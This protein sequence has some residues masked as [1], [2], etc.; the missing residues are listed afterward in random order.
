MDEELAGKSSEDKN[1]TVRVDETG[2][3]KRMI[4]LDVSDVALQAEKK[5]ISK[6]LQ[7]DLEVPG[8]RKGKVPASFVEKNY[9]GAVHGDAVQNLL[10]KAYEEAIVG[11]DLR[12][13]GEPRFEDLKA[14]DGEGISV[15]A[16]IEVKPEVEIKDY[17][18]VSL[19]AEKKAIGDEEVDGT[20]ETLVQNMASFQTVDRPA[21]GDDYIV[22]DFAPLLD[23]GE[24]DEAARQQ[25]YGVTLDGDGLL[26]EFKQGLQGMSAGDEKEILVKY[27][28]DFAEKN[29]AGSGKSFRVKVS[30]VKEKLL[31]VL[32]DAF[33]KSISSEVES[34]Q[35]LRGRIQQDLQRE[36][37][38]KHEQD[39]QEKVI[40]KIIE[41]NSFEVP[42]TMVENYLTSIVEEDRRRR[43]NV[44][45]EEQR[46][47]Q[48]REMFR[49][50]AARMV[51]RYLIMEAVI[52]QENLSVTSEE[53][54]KKIDSLAEGTGRPVEEVEKMFRDSRHRRNLENELLDQK[55]LNF[56]RVKA[57]IKDV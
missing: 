27:P 40:D 30:E 56:L 47:T 32:D 23:S 16:H 28:D 5:R 39:I 38:A 49:E 2:Q 48:V 29:L 44:E 52:R 46:E 4:T 26:P 24:P 19:E 9:A 43:P 20:L 54:S 45:S 51:K 33:A 17:I 6:K 8:F 25:N 14:E 36:E 50:P 15:K 53:I 3:C 21:A 55:V 10:A 41:N 13:L 31:P 37:D 42:E 12:P 1:F 7:T 11:Q 35:E 57:D 18:G 34:L 22:I